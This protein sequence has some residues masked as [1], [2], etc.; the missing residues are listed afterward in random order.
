M[1]K[2]TVRYNTL[3]SS[4]PLTA[5]F[6]TSSVTKGDDVQENGSFTVFYNN[7]QIVAM[8]PTN[9]IVDVKAVLEIGANA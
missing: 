9:S 3:G 7:L 8:I 5:T 6:E 1:P 2:Y 4:S